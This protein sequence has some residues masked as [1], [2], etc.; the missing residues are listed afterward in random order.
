MSA[1]EVTAEGSTS[2]RVNRQLGLLRGEGENPQL[3]RKSIFRPEFMPF[4][5]N[6]IYFFYH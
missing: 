4:T 5:W 6:R 2:P 3:P 1:Q